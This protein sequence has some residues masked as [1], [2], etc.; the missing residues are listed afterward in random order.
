M[1]H[2]MVFMDNMVGHIYT[3]FQFL[4]NKGV[5]ILPLSKCRQR[6]CSKEASLLK[7]FYLVR[8]GNYIPD[9]SRNHILSFFLI[10]VRKIISVQ[11]IYSDRLF[12]LMNMYTLGVRIHT[13]VRIRTNFRESVP[14]RLSQ[15]PGQCVLHI[16]TKDFRFFWIIAFP[17]CW[18]DR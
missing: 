2:H 9:V 17:L 14:P 13:R 15:L 16:H 5:L 6:T 18:F 7:W 10:P 11:E 1:Y 8:Y 12:G 4:R 3:P